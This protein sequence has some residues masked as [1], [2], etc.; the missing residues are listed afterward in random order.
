MGRFRGR[1]GNAVTRLL[2]RAKKNFT[3]GHFRETVRIPKEKRG[4][5]KRR[6]AGRCYATSGKGGNASK[7]LNL[8]AA[9]NNRTEKYRRKER[10]T[11]SRFWRKGQG[12]DVA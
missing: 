7:P 6:G 9:R 12:K 10:C 4:G 2:T 1:R 3:A 5:R 11:S 8:I